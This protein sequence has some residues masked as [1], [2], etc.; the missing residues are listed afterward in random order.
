M[1]K[2]VLIADDSPAFRQL[3]G[4]YLTKRGLAL[5]YAEDGLQA[6]KIALE[7]RPDLILLDIQMPVMDGVQALALLKSQPT[8]KD[9]PVIVI[10]TLGHPNVT[11]LKRAGAAD[12]LCKPVRATELWN[13]IEPFVTEG[14]RPRS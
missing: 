8:T 13:A 14:W 12:V 4:E 1:P 5:L 11:I 3:E 6:A 10:T 9:I 2:T 7:A